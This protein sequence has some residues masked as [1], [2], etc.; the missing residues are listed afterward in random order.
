MEDTSNKIKVAV[1][2]PGYGSH[3]R[4][5][6][7]AYDEADILEVF[8]TGMLFPDN[9]FFK[10]LSHI[11]KG[12]KSKQFK[13]IKPEKIQKIQFPEILRLFSNNYFSAKNTDKIWEWSELYFD[14]WVANRLNADINIFHGYEHA[15][16]FTL[17]KCMQKNIFSVYEQPSAHH[18]YVSRN[19]IAPLLLK[20]PA[21]KNNFGELYDSDLSRSR[22]SRRD[23][24]LKIAN[25]ILCNSSYVKKTLLNAGIDEDKIL[26]HPLGFPEV[27]PVEIYSKENLT[28]MVS[29]NLSYLKGTHHVLRVWKNNPEIFKNHKLICI[30]SDTLSQ[31]EW[32]GLPNNVEKHNRLASDEYLNMLNAVDV[33][34]LN[35]YSDG[36]GMVM[37]EAMSYGKAVIGTHNSAALDIIENGVSGKVIPVGNEEALKNEMMWMINNPDEVMKMRKSAMEY[38]KNHSWNQYR[39][40]LAELIKEK[41]IHFNKR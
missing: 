2:N 14:H 40:D 29:G 9:K 26:V 4:Q 17:Q 18:L 34:I 20:E 1:A 33:Y 23:E 27:K 11:F 15:C 31:E 8:F 37:S 3:V 22:N 30:G 12:I 7:R 16:L 28:F 41:Y 25:L 32:F 24:E 38:A 39:I 21:F 19:V 5:S 35:T 6:V 13:E 36:F 10:K